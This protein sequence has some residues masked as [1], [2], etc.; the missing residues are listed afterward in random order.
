MNKLVAAHHTCLVEPTPAAAP[1]EDGEHCSGEP[2]G[3]A[4]LDLRLTTRSE[5]TRWRWCEIH[6]LRVQGL[7]MAVIARRLGLDFKTVRRYLRADSI[8]QLVAGGVRASKLD[9]F[10]PYLHQRL[11]TSVRDATAL[12]AEILNQGYTGSYHTVER[13]LKPMRLTDAAT[14]AQVLRNRPPPVRQ[15]TAWITGPPGHLDTADEARLKAIRARCPE[16]DAAVRR[17]VAG[18]ARMIKDLAGDK[19]KLTAWTAAIDHDLPTLRSFTVGLR[20]DIEAVTAGLT[21]KY[22]SGA[23]EGTVN[24]IKARKMQLFGRAK[25]DL[26][27]KLILLS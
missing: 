10:K 18:F 27:R 17:H 3:R 15:V 26:L 9:P 25:H 23:V 11:T 6:A 7:S 22:N 24:K 21:Q 20:R 12:H 8:E 4:V 16:I 1:R 2:A 13:Y 5:R 14:L 19:D